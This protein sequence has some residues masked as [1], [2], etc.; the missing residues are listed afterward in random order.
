MRQWLL[1]GRLPCLTPQQREKR[2]RWLA[3]E[4]L[5]TCGAAILAMLSHFFLIGFFGFLFD[6]SFC[7]PSS[8]SMIEA[9]SFNLHALRFDPF[10]LPLGR[11]LVAPDIAS[12]SLSSL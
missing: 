11:T 1:H 7:D 10:G 12:A 6:F 9:E 5:T 4:Y 2:L 3:L 8:P